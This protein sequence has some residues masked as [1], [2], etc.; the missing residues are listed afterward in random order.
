MRGG[1]SALLTA[2]LIVAS[3]VGMTPRLRNAAG[4]E[5]CA[6]GHMARNR[7][8]SFSCVVS[9]EASPAAKFRLALAGREAEALD[10]LAL[11]NVPANQRILRAQYLPPPLAPGVLHLK[12]PPACSDGQKPLI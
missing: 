12:I 11:L 6:V 3:V 1:R 4:R 8:L 2:L 10:V 5:T 7:T 9:S